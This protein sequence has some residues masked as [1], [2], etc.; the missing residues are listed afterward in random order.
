MIL[1]LAYALAIGRGSHWLWEERTQFGKVHLFFTSL[2]DEQT[3]GINGKD[4]LRGN[5]SEDVKSMVIRGSRC[6][7][8]LS[9]CRWEGGSVSH[10]GQLHFLHIYL[11]THFLRLP[12]TRLLQLVSRQRTAAGEHLTEEKYEG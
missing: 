10:L 4:F 9:V 11:P 5:P 6:E 2:K 8:H 3:R 7:G 12:A 1:Y